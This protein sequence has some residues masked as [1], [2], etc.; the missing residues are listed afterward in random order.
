MAELTPPEDLQQPTN[1]EPAPES[2]PELQLEEGAP[3]TPG[4]VPL[5]VPGPELEPKPGLEDEE[6]LG[7]EREQNDEEPEAEER[8]PEHEEKLGEEREQEHEEPEAK[9]QL[10]LE[11]VLEPVPESRPTGPLPPQAEREPEPC[12]PGARVK[13]GAAAGSGPGLAL[14]RVPE[15]PAGVG[16]AAG[17]PA[18]ETRAGADTDDG[19]VLVCATKEMA[20]G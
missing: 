13:S 3:E 8:E 11:P 20:C 18:P 9:E 2:V 10:V 5:P 16:S 1:P 7:K 4:P 12:K 17:E 6:K 15:A 14:S 19:E